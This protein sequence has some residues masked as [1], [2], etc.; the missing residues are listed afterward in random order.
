M[1]PIRDEIRTHSFPA[2]NYLL[3]GLNVL[4]FFLMALAG[5]SQET[6]VYQMALLPANLKNG[7]NINDITAQ[8]TSLKMS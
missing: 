8:K 5:S 3:I 7:I 2:F 1:N 6:L 4:V